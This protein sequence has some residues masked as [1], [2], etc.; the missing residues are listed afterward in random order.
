MFLSY[1]L[2]RSTVVLLIWAGPSKEGCPPRKRDVLL[3]T[4]QHFS[5]L[6]VYGLFLELTSCQR[7]LQTQ[8]SHVQ[9][10]RGE[11]PAENVHNSFPPS[12]LRSSAAHSRLQMQH[13]HGASWEPPARE[14]KLQFLPP[15]DKL[16]QCSLTWGSAD[17]EE[18]SR[19]ASQ[20]K[21]GK[22]CWEDLATCRVWGL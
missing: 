21:V 1:T 11:A 6:T 4:F 19:R 15:E 8:R 22:S 7:S 3:F 10:A 13:T 18:L 16:S 12:I 20:P 5:S 2:Q 14:T 17:P 9:L